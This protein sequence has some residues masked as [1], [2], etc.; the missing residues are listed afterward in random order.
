MEMR[1]VPEPVLPEAQQHEHRPSAS[2]LQGA[3]GKNWTRYLQLDA[4]LAERRKEMTKAQQMGRALARS[5]AQ[6]GR[7]R[8]RIMSVLC[9]TIGIILAISLGLMIG[10]AIRRLRGS[11]ALQGSLGK[12]VYQ[13]RPG[14]PACVRHWC[15]G[16]CDCTAAGHAE[17]PHLIFLHT[18]KTG[19]S[20]VEC[21]TQ[22]PRLKP[23]WT[24]LQ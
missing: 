8:W 17:A 19:G 16:D 23:H 1:T 18:E 11:P 15:G 5:C 20:S 2:L 24:N 22:D 13:F 3:R 12:A 14:E 9:W 7:V 21:A 4:I 10:T 6:T